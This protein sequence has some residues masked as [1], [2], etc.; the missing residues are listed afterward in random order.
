MQSGLSIAGAAR[1]SLHAANHQTM[2]AMDHSRQVAILHELL[3]HTF[4]AALAQQP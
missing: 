4:D 2:D 3:S 1:N